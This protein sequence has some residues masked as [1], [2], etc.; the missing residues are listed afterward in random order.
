MDRDLKTRIISALD[1]L[2]ALFI[3]LTGI[4]VILFGMTWSNYL[5]TLTESTLKDWLTNTPWILNFIGFAT[6]LYGIKRF[7]TQLIRVAD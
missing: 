7:L 3:T 2:I 4:F 6:I 1:V 5:D